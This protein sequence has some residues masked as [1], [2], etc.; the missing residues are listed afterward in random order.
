MLKN[1]LKI[2]L[3]NMSR[4]KVYSI[5]NI[6]GLSTGIA[7]C[8]LLSLYIENEISYDKHHSR[9]DD[10]YVITTHFH[11]EQGENIQATGS[12]P[13]APTMQTEIPEIE[14]AARL[15]N[16]P[17]AAQN[18]I[19]YGDNIFYENDGFLADSTI[20]N[21]LTY[22]FV[23]GHPRKALTDAN[24][25]VI[26]D[27][28]SKKLFGNESALNKVISI[29]LSGHAVDYK[30]TGVIK[31][32]AKSFVHVNFITSITSQGWA[33]WIRTD[34]AMGEWAGENFVPAYVKLVAGHN[35]EDVVK[36]M[37]QVLAKYGAADLKAMG[38]TKT[39]G[40]V[41]V[42]DIYLKS[43]NRQSPRITFLYVIGSIAVF[44]LLIACINF[45][46]LSTARATKRAAEIG[47]R[48][49]MG[50]FR[51]SLIK[52]ILGEAMVI[53]LISVLFSIIIVQI[54]L[55]FL[56]EFTGENISFDRENIS[57]FIAA[58]FVLTI[59]TGIIAGSYPA[60]YLSSF[61][62]AQVLKGKLNIGNASGTLRR[63]LVVFQFMIGIVLVCGMI[64]ITKQLNY[65]Q[66]K[67]LG[68]NA[69]AKIILPLRTNI[70]REN[71][72]ALQSELRRH[73]AV[74][75]ISAADYL[76]GQPIFNDMSFYP[77]GGNMETAVQHY[78]NKVDH[79]YLELLGIKLLAGRTFTDNNG[80][81]DM[82]VVVNRS[83][84]KNLGFD[85][86]TAV[87]QK[88]YYEWQGKKYAWEIIGVMEDYH[89]TSLKR[90][91][92][93][94]LFEMPEDSKEFDNIIISIN[95][96]NF[97]QTIA[98]IEKT[99][100]KIIDD[101]PFEYVFLDESI[102]KQ[103]NADRKVS[104]IITTFTFVAIFISCLG[105]YGLSSYMAERRFKEI[106]VRKVMGANVNQILGLMSIEFVKLVVIAFIIAVP[107]AWYGMDKWLEGFAYKTTIDVLVFVYAGLGALG[108]ALITVS[109][110]SFR[111]A[112]TNPVKSL[113]T[114]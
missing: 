68:F 90:E 8:L 106:G 105:L 81:E 3:R 51:S 26:T 4:N 34:D 95:T 108:I 69:E 101:T 97:N 32:N 98:S 38:M 93:P 40:L 16:P 92:S 56:S 78:R 18:L 7:C 113:R 20:F 100:K 60:F 89:Q 47:M 88:I 87:G 84:V 15:I 82:K 58:L 50:A 85:V 63:L 27:K 39:L 42:K 74:K 37:N 59:F 22:E 109:F 6:F 114:E 83:G 14:A 45:M 1:Y 61:Q 75:Q 9:L 19:K 73:S 112:T 21:I 96:A 28:V 111:A 107:L 46:N 35:K 48:K 24:T 66:E 36:K 91:I 49:V 23:E 86:E 12:P 65:L 79:G 25:V 13:I 99:W 76:P 103:Y 31:D 77:D 29:S 17:S 104:Q 70:A 72:K 62:P 52:Q 33:E 102:Q 57:Y 10:L 30:I 54:A 110:E 53:V 94:T 41:P 71:Y 2:A 64:I 43:V 67:D 44:I 5:I 11:S 55:P 80:A